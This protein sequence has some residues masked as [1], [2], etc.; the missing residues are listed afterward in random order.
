VD[1]VVTVREYA[2]RFSVPLGW[3]R[4]QIRA[5]LI[6]HLRAGRRILLNPTAV[7]EALSRMASQYPIPAGVQNAH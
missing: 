7:S 4:A 5:G 3:L 2:R 1:E 6:P